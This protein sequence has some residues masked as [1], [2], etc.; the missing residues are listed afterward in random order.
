MRRLII[1]ASFIMSFNLYAR[2][3][4]EVKNYPTATTQNFFKIGIKL[5][6]GST[7]YGIVYPG[8]Y[9][10]FA[11]ENFMENI[12]IDFSYTFGPPLFPYFWYDG[13]ILVGQW[14]KEESNYT[15]LPVSFIRKFQPYMLKESIKIKVKETKNIG[16]FFSL[17][18]FVVPTEMKSPHL[19]HACYMAMNKYY[20]F[21]SVPSI[22]L[23]IRVKKAR[24][25][26]ILYNDKKIKL[27]TTPSVE[28]SLSKDYGIFILTNIDGGGIFYRKIWEGI[29]YKA[30]Y[31]LQFFYLR[32]SYLYL[33]P[34]NITKFVNDQ[35]YGAAII[36]SIQSK[37]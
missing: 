35:M 29:S 37:L 20:R 36:V 5:T 11:I 8:L 17:F 26:K 4:L 9:T 25:F 12:F 24:N 10:G 27:L 21:T 23:G 1:L 33:T 3:L 18:P 13:K 14:F 16:V 30:Y 28:N 15:T 34:Q 31:E 7:P 22:K 32:H 19:S 6:I 2:T